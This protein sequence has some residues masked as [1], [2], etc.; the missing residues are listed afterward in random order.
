M[1]TYLL[2][3]LS[4][5]VLLS[6]ADEITTAVVDYHDGEVALQGFFA[7]PSGDALCPAVLV[8]PEWWGH[9]A[10]VQNRARELAAAGY[11]AF[12][13]DMYGTGLVTE[14]PKQA[15]EWAGPFYTDSALL[16]RRV[17]AGLATLR[18]QP[19]VDPHGISAMGFCFGGTVCLQLARSGE[20]LAKVISL[21][22]GLATTT[23]AQAETLKA[24]ILVLHGGSDILVPPADVAAF[25]SE[26]VASQADWR[27]EIY[28]K[29]MHA[30][31]NP[32]ASPKGG[33]PIGYDAE[34]AER[35][36][37]QV[38]TFLADGTP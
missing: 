38:M 7:R 31:T 3:L 30:F 20:D 28:G 12:A 15:G 21:H 29:A 17:R 11:A 18:A 35:A 32:A 8:V 37:A 2:A 14:D 26:M 36:M 27:M 6:A 5:A 23:P 19:G 10:Y 1:R 22:G 24:R 13:V 4:F 34:A 25:M 33:L 9:N 16:L